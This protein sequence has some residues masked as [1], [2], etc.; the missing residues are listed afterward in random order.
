MLD[1]RGIS[2]CISIRQWRN[3]QRPNILQDNIFQQYEVRSFL[4]NRSLHT[5]FPELA[6]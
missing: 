6:N 4:H 3:Q 2:H 1:D 5:L